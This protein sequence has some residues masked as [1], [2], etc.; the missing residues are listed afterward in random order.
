M[1][2]WA[3]QRRALADEREA[4]RR[5]LADA[6]G[7]GLGEAM[8]A[9]AGE[10]SGYDQHPA[11]LGS[12]MFEREKQLS[13][14][15]DDEKRL[16]IIERALGKLAAGGYGA[17]EACGRAIPRAR[18]EAEPAALYCIGCERARAG[19]AR[20]RARPVE[21]DLL[22]PPFART[23]MDRRDFTGFDGEDSWQAVE[24]FNSRRAAGRDPG[25]GEPDGSADCVEPVEAVSNEDYRR[26]LPD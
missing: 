1:P 4:I 9:A 8:N 26:Q 13:L 23:D 22:R 16:E 20:M 6:R 15:R 10:L 19:A 3:H 2:H 11:D 21:E 12:E 5:R 17:C 14:R 18:L 7:C 25:G 24:R